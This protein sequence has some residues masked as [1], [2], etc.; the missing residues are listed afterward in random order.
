MAYLYFGAH[1]GRFLAALW[2]SQSIART[3]VIPELL[4]HDLIR[5]DLMTGADPVEKLVRMHDQLFVDIW[6]VVAIQ[7]KSGSFGVV[8]WVTLRLLWEQCIQPFLRQRGL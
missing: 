1:A 5:Q 8:V 2:I 7:Q 4:C 3:L 6:L